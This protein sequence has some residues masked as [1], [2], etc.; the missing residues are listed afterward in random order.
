MASLNGSAP[1]LRTG[2]DMHVPAISPFDARHRKWR[3]ES[4]RDDFYIVHVKNCGANMLENWNV[5][6]L[7]EL[8]ALSPASGIAAVQSR[9]T[10][11]ACKRYDASE[12]LYRRQSPGCVAPIEH[13]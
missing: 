8:L 1:A 4:E 13:E 7:K 2:L 11:R 9:S 3:L 10:D 12:S 5:F 6:A